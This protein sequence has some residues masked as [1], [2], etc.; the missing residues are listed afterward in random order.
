MTTTNEQVRR[1][2]AEAYGTRVRPVL[3][4][5]AMSVPMAAAASCC[6][7]APAASSCCGPAEAEASACCGEDA[8]DSTVD[9]IAALYE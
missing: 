9:R 2:V 6:A 7:P 4:A 5:D 1:E 3:E 8:N